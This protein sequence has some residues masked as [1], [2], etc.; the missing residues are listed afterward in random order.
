MLFNKVS[1][2]VVM[3]ANV[4]CTAARCLHD[5]QRVSPASL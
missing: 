4:D 1:G 2:R 3:V 5:I